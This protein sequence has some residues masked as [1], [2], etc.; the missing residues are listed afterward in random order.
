MMTIATL[1]N[2][3]IFIYVAAITLAFA[4]PWV[5][6]LIEPLILAAY[7]IFFTAIF[8]Q[9]LYGSSCG[10]LAKVFYIVVAPSLIFLLFCLW[11][12][13]LFYGDETIPKKSIVFYGIILLLRIEITELPNQKTRE[14]LDLL[15]EI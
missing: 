8:C 12:F 1:S 4:I 14:H 5:A 7:Q 3:R 6:Y 11:N 13:K 9:G 10:A 15:A 2:R